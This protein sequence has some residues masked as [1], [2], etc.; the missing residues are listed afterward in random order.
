MI[1]SEQQINENI[2]ISYTNDLKDKKFQNSD[3]KVFSFNIRSL[4]HKFEELTNFIESQD[5]LIHILVISEI[6]IYAS[7]NISFQIQNYEAFMCNRDS[8]RGGGVAIYIHKSINANCL[9]NKSIDCD[10]DLLLIELI[11]YNIKIFGVYNQPA[12]DVNKFIELVS[13]ILNTNTNIFMLGDT[14]I[15]L[16]ENSSN[17]I[18]YSNMIYSNGYTV[19]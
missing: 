13:N 16:L 12:A 9:Y 5:F 4:R 14:N 15:N 7:E 18:N 11:N 19:F 2:N 6:W 8:N 1:Q 10:Y 17:T 3:L